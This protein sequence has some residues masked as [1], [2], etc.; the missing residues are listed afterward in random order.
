MNMGNVNEDENKTLRNF[1]D[2]A[3]FTTEIQIKPQSTTS[4]PERNLHRPRPAKSRSEFP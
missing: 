4:F 1:A 2:G 3:A